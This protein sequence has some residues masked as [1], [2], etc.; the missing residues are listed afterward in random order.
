[1]AKPR[2]R[3][4]GNR[5]IAGLVAACGVIVALNAPAAPAV[6]EDAPLI[7]GNAV[8][9][10]GDTIRIGP[11]SIRIHGID[12]PEQDQTCDKRSG[13]KWRCGEAATGAMSA[14]VKGRTVECVPLDTDAYRRIVARCHAG[15]LDL[16]AEMVGRGFAWAYRRYADDYTQAEGI[17]RANGRG[18][19]QGEALPAWE[20]R[21]DRWAR[22]AAQ[23]PE[24]CPIKGNIS[25]QGERIYH[26][27]W[28]PAY[29]KTRIDE[30]KGERWFCDEAEAISAGWRAARWR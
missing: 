20:Y 3:L 30:S 4:A 11:V 28:S 26:T 6:T 25:N 22:A 12:A 16:G 1:M 24:R 29:S 23:T 15:D 10:D 14:L 7:A 17:A 27:P 21:A 8:V 5:V 13:Q 9:V 18:I 19:W 2:V